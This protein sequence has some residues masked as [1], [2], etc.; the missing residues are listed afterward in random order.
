MSGKHPIMGNRH[1]TITHLA[2]LSVHSVFIDY[3]HFDEAGIEPRYEFGFG[4][5]Y[6]SFE[7]SD[8]KIVPRAHGNEG[9]L[10]EAWEKGDVIDHSVGSSLANWSVLSPAYLSRQCL[11]WFCIHVPTDLFPA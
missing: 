4:M 11:A 1:H 3:R 7:Y 9:H 6:T 5:S 8:L 2:L 10:E